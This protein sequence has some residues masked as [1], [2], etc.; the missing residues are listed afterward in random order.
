MSFYNISIIP[1]A[2][3]PSLH[4]PQD[5]IP[6]CV[7]A[8]VHGISIHLLVCSEFVCKI[9]DYIH[10]P[11]VYHLSCD[12]LYCNKFHLESSMADKVANKHCVTNVQCLGFIRR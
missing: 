7:Q 12:G 9:F 5:Y 4:G 2:K 6:A 3:K 1:H 11:H 10:E 8:G